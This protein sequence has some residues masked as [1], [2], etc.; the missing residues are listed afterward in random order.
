[1]PEA[2][3]QAFDPLSER[4]LA[5]ARE[6]ETRVLSRA[7]RITYWSSSAA[8]VAAA[9][10]L[11]LVAPAEGLPETWVVGLLVLSYA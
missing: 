7:E 10:A 6:R 4:L 8:F 5:E 9:L 11:L 3:P 1:M 2:S